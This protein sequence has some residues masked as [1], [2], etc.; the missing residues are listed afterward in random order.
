MADYGV[1]SGVSGSLPYPVLGIAM[2]LIEVSGNLVAEFA[3]ESYKHGNRAYRE[4]GEVSNLIC[5]PVC[6]E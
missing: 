4:H 5:L 2:P 1:L 6:L 3:A